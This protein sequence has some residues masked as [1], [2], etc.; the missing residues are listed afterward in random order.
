MNKLNCLIYSYFLEH[1]DHLTWTAG[2]DFDDKFGINFDPDKQGW[3]ISS[4]TV[5]FE[6]R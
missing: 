1:I 5:K 6:S 3:V 2:N 4:L